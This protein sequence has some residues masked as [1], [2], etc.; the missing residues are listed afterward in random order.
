MSVG[1][2]A[3]YRAAR[4]F[5][6]DY[7]SDFA[8]F[9]RHRVRGAMLE[10]LDGLF[11]E[12]RVK[13]AAARAEEN[14]CGHHRDKEYNVMKHDEVEARRRYRAF[15][16]GLLAA[17]FTAALEEAVQRLDTAELAQRIEYEQAVAHLRAA[18]AK[19][20]EADR[21]MFA[22][23]YRDLL[24]LKAASEA[25]GIP[26]GTARARH[27]RALRLLHDF[28]VEQGVARAPRPLVVPD[29]G[30]LFAAPQNDTGGDG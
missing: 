30:A 17:T 20:T 25:L 26:Y 4:A 19:L 21:R 29:A 8:S 23:M 1:Q 10:S 15:A 13:L 7:N 28:L 14:Y 16:S 2:V 27:A 18:L 24:D 11:F 5:R 22:L 6:D 3:L 12:E 9:A